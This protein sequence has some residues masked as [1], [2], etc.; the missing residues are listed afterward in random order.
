MSQEEE[1]EE[2]ERGL[3]KG[4][5]RGVAWVE[6]R[7]G[8]VCTVC[9]QARHTLVYAGNFYQRVC[10]CISVCIHAYAGLPLLCWGGQRGV[11]VGGGPA[12]SP[13]AFTD[14]IYY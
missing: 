3:I 11:G 1:E 4:R 8:G 2:E 12:G 5:G 10:I 7:W 9:T 6:G 13:R 14:Q